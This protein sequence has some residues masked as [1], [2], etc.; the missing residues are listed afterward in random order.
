MNCSEANVSG[1]SPV[2]VM[3]SVSMKAPSHAAGMAPVMPKRPR[4]IP[5]TPHCFSGSDSFLAASRNSPSQ[6]QSALG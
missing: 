5:L 1:E 6:V 4:L 2:K 3:V